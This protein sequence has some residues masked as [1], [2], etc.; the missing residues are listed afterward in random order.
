MIF[1][2]SLILVNPKTSKLTTLSLGGCSLD[3]NDLSPLCNAIKD[4]LQLSMLKLSANRITDEGVT[5]L[6][7]ALLKNKTNPLAVLDLSTN[8]VNRL[9]FFFFYGI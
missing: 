6:V 9:Y 1:L 3:D 4:G 8:R 2:I 7:E 5:K